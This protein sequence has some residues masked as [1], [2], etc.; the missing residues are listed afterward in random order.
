MLMVFLTTSYA[1][2]AFHAVN[3]GRIASMYRTLWASHRLRYLQLNIAQLV[4]W[5]G[6]FLIGCR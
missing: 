1:I 6:G 5:I 2:V 4:A 3:V